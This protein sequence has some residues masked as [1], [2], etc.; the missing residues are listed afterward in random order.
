MPP[1]SPV[2]S[3]TPD[4]PQRSSERFFGLSTPQVAGSALAAGTSALAASFLGVGGTI[5]GALVGSIVATIASAVYS[6]SLRRAGQR[7]RVLRPV[8]VN[9]RAPD[10]PQVVAGPLRA[11]QPR[12]WPHLVIGVV[13]GA[14]IAL[15]AITGIEAMLGHPISD[16]SRSGTS[17]TDAFSGQG[18]PRQTRVKAPVPAA[19]TPAPAV[20]ATGRADSPTPT[21]TAT[22]QA[23]TATPATPAPTTQ[24]AGEPAPSPAPTTPAPTSPATPPTPGP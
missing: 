15:G 14:V 10:E 21:A 5:I 6:H 1:N 20:T 2:S 11:G 18:G 4:A 9:G 17:V 22:G 12:R 3:T 13:A 7:L 8:P 16:S 23:A 19:T 24:Q